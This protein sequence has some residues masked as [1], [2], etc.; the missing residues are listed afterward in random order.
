MSTSSQDAPSGAFFVCGILTILEPHS[1]HKSPLQ[2]T[3]EVRFVIGQYDE[4][5]IH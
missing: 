4:I 5:T 2:H 3:I 1:E